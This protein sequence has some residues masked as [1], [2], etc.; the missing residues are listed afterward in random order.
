MDERCYLY[1][2]CPSQTAVCPG[3]PEPDEGC[4]VYRYF[5]KIIPKEQWH[6][7]ESDPPEDKN[8]VLGW[9]I[10]EKGEKSFRICEKVRDEWFTSLFTFNDFQREEKVLQW[11]ELPKPP[12]TKDENFPRLYTADE[13]TRLTVNGLYWMEFKLS[14]GRIDLIHQYFLTGHRTSKRMAM[15]GIDWRVWT[16]KPTQRQRE[17]THWV[18]G[19]GSG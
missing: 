7:A 11:M 4:P 8:L 19:G 17:M 18:P 6:D 3:M 12:E 2:H 14:S 9:C 15:Y 1:G 16:D 13:I 5:R 10:D